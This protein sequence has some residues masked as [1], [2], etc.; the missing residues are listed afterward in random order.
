[1]QRGEKGVGFIV[2]I[3]IGAVALFSFIVLNLDKPTA[4]VVNIDQFYESDVP[5]CDTLV[6]PSGYTAYY[7]GRFSKFARCCCNC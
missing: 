3:V 7:M 4:N 5:P 2:L 1:M 6:C